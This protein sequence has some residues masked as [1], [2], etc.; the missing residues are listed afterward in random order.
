MSPPLP[1]A[2]RNSFKY[3]IF[4]SNAKVACFKPVDKKTEDKHCI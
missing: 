2:I 1:I 3:N 4:P